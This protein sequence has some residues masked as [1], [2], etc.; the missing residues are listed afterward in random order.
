MFE[1]K[2]I[3]PLLGI[4]GTKIKSFDTID[5]GDEST[6]YIELEDI[7]GCCPR[8]GSTSI[9]IKDYYEVHINNSIIK[10]RHLTVAIRVRRYRCRKCG[11]TFKQEY[12]FTEKGASISNAV[13]LA[14]IN[15][16]KEKLTATQIA[17]DHHVSDMTV[18]RIFDTA[19]L[20]QLSLKLSE[21]ICIDEFCY[22]HS[23][24]KEGNHHMYK[25]DL[26]DH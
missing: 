22:K 15:D 5:D 11:K 1:A 4:P 25:R 13:K 26:I 20:P 17:K 14:I 16:L 12:Q 24:C 23:N 10:H 8:C 6:I 18:L 2:D 19:I 3:L 9:E 21:I 7:R